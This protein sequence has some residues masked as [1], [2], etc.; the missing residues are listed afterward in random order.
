MTTLYALS[1]L[2]FLFLFLLFFL[3]GKST[4]S[5]PQAAHLPKEG[6]QGARMNSH[7]VGPRSIEGGGPPPRPQG[8]S[9]PATRCP[10]MPSPRPGRPRHA[11]LTAGLRLWIHHGLRTTV[12]ATTRQWTG[13][14]NPEGASLQWHGR[15][16]PSL[17]GTPRSNFLSP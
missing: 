8:T 17:A 15:P 16:A 12:P 6:A 9:R 13:L 4:R 7:A 14:N 11:Q 2:S 5:W 3:P 1:F 10:G